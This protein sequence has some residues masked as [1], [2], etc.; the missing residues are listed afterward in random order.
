[1]HIDNC[2]NRPVPR[3]AARAPAGPSAVRPERLDPDW[4]GQAPHRRDGK[5]GELVLERL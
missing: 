4:A 5:V 2:P 3:S 1:M